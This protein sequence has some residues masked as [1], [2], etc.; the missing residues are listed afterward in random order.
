MQTNRELITG[1]K[2]KWT[3]VFISPLRLS[4]RAKRG[5][6]LSPLHP[7]PVI[8][9]E[10]RQ[11]FLSPSPLACHC[12]RSAAILSL[13][14]PLACHCER[15]AAISLSVISYQSVDYYIFN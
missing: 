10:A 11:S 9:S 6:P 12:E 15:S 3:K 2:G 5:N 14:R 7:S 13:P 8:A 1:N 4:L